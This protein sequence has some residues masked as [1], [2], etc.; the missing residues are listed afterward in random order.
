MT[1][2]IVYDWVK[3]DAEKPNWNVMSIFDFIARRAKIDLYGTYYCDVDLS[4]HDAEKPISNDIELEYFDKTQ[5]YR[6]SVNW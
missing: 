1:P 2:I 5:N 4:K 6:D 3:H